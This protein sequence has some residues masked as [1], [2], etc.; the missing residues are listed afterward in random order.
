MG[1]GGGGRLHDRIHYG[2]GIDQDHC[3]TNRNTHSAN[4]NT[5]ANASDMNRMIILVVGFVLSGCATV[6]KGFVTGMIGGVAVVDEVKHKEAET[7]SAHTGLKTGAH[8]VTASWL[9]ASCWPCAVAFVGT[10]G[11]YG[12]YQ[13]WKME[14]TQDIER[15]THRPIDV[16]SPGGNDGRHD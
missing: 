5:N 14:F 15:Q 6:T 11:I 1:S 12:A 8:L 13:F 9:A 4:T 7:G 3:R 10:S 2:P 16:L